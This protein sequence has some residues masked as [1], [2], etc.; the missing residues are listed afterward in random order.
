MT[1]AQRANGSAIPAGAP[2]QDREGGLLDERSVL[3]HLE[4]CL[5][6][7]PLR[8]SIGIANGIAIGIGI[9]LVIALVAFALL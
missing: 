6:I 3:D 9:W 8:P 1:A 5:L 2:A 4:P 7:D